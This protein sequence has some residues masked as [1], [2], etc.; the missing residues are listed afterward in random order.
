VYAVPI[1]VVGLLVH[2]SGMTLKQRLEGREAPPLAWETAL[3]WLCWA[4]LAGLGV[5]LALQRVAA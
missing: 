4:C 2:G 1:L 5:W 3:F